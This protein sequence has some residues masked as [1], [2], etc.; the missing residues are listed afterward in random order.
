M[1]LVE[2][3]ESIL[4]PVAN[5]L[6]LAIVRVAHSG[7][8]L[9]ILLEKTDGSAP[10][11]GECESAARAFSAHLDVEDLIAGRYFLEVGSA[12]MDRPL[13]KP[14]DFARFVGREAEIGLKL[15]PGESGRGTIK[16]RIESAGAASAVIGGV[17]IEFKNISNA[18]LLITDEQIRQILKERK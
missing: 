13:V 12:G 16:G 9:Q 11:I 5:G 8:A 17:E 1:P 4:S 3:I 2:K 18:K 15:P 10:A 7:K 14:E 6:G